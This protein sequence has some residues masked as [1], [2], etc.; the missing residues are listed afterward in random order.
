MVLNCAPVNGFGVRM[1][2][3][4]RLREERERLGLTQEAFGAAGGVLK[5]AVINYE[6]GER[7]P[8]ASFMAG[9][10]AAGAD[11]QYIVTGK[12]ASADVAGLTP[13]EA[14]LLAIYKQADPDARQALQ[15]VAFLAARSGARAGVG[16]TVTIGGD[17][18]QQ[19]NGDQTVTAPMTFSVGGKRKK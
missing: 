15:S 3:F 10:A 16:N 6:K 9:I 5:R 1:S 8:D 2:I 7:F 17:V 14:Q 19:V 11:V 18:G 13:D 4:L 12:R